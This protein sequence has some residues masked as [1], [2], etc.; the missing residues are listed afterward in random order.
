MAR[1]AFASAFSADTDRASTS[2]AVRFLRRTFRTDCGHS[3][4]PDP[5]AVH[6]VGADIE[7]GGV[8]WVMPVAEEECP[9]AHRRVAQELGERASGR[10]LLK[11]EGMWLALAGV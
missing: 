1:V 4:S 8:R 7:E 6:P 9:L 3:V 11:S 2:V 10:I 5:K